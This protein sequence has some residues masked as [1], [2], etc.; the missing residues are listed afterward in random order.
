MKCVIYQILP[1]WASKGSCSIHVSGYDLLVDCQRPTL[2]PPLNSSRISVGT[3]AGRGKATV[4]LKRGLTR[5][6]RIEQNSRNRQ[7]A[8]DRLQSRV[9]IRE[10]CLHIQTDQK[11]RTH[12]VEIICERLNRV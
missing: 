6:P 10:V 1:F 12:T 8:S 3:S 5:C 2:I 11:W 9:L 4:T 7:S